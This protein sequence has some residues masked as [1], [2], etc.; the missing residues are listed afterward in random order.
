MELFS[1]KNL[2]TDV[3]KI[4]LPFCSLYSIQTA[5]EA[6][7]KKRVDNPCAQLENLLLN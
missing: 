4:V 6:Y 7:Q 3:L 2:D 1:Y 5:K